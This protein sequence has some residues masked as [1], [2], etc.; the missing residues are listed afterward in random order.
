MPMEHQLEP[1]HILVE[2]ARAVSLAVAERPRPVGTVTFLFSDIEG[3]TRMW[4]RFAAGMNAALAR[5]DALMLRAIEDAGGVVFKTVGDAFCAVFDRAGDA[6]RASLAA[7]TAIAAEDWSAFSSGF[8]PLRVRMALHTGTAS[9][10]DDDYFGPVLNRVA[11]LEAAGHGGQVLVSLVTQQLLRDGLPDGVTLRD[12]GEHTLKDLTH[13][14]HIYEVITDLLV[15]TSE[16][17][18]TAGQLAAGERILVDDAAD[19][20]PLPAALATL[21]AVVRDE[22]RTVTLSPEALR[23]VAR[24]P[25]ADLEVY[26]LGRVAAWS[27]SQFRLD[28]RFVELALLIDQGE[29]TSTGRWAARDERFS[30]LAVLVAAAPDPA[31]VV[32]GPPGSGKSTLLRRLELDASVAALRS[33]A[34]DAPITFYLELNHYK[35]DSPGAPLPLPMEWLASNWRLR[36]PD[37]PELSTLLRTSQV[38]LLLDAL[39]EM[40]VADESA[41]RE[42]TRR[43]KDFIHQTVQQAPRTRLVFTCRSLDYSAPLSTPELRVPQVRIE[44]MSDDQ[45]RQF[46]R[47]YSP[48]DWREIWDELHRSQQLELVRSP[49]FLKLLV[50]QVAD[51]GVVPHGRAALF[52]GFVRQ[53]LRR[54]LER[55]NPLFNPG[56][57]LSTRDCRRLANW[58]WRTEWEL[59]DHGLLIPKLFDLAYS[60]QAEHADGKAAHL[61]L[62]YDAALE[63]LADQRD[64][65]ILR[66][67]M[68]LSVL[69]EDT[70]SDEI[71]YV[72][73]LVQEY[74][75]AQRL[76]TTPDGVADLVRSPWRSDEVQPSLAEIERMITP[77]D[78]L[79]PLPTTGWEQTVLM[80]AAMTTEPDRFVQAVMDGNLAL[81]GWCAAQADVQLSDSTRAQLAEA[82]VVRS[83]DPE[84]DLRARIDAASAVGRMGDPRFER[85]QGTDGEYLLPPMVEIP[86]G[87]YIVG[88]DDPNAED[89]SPAHHVSLAAFRLGMFP[90]TNAEWAC[91]MAAGG[92]DDPRWW[93]TNAARAWQHGE[94]TAEGVRNGLRFWRQRYLQEPGLL[95]ARLSDGRIDAERYALWRTRLAMDDG[96][97][98]EDLRASYRGGRETAPRYWQDE[99]F[100]LPS[101]PVIGVSWFESRAYVLWLSAQSG[102][103]FRLPSEAEWEAAARGSDGR[104]YAFGDFAFEY[105]CN[106]VEAHV[107]RTTPVGVFPSGDTPEGLADM[108]GNI[109]EWTN[110]LFGRRQDRADYRYPYDPDDGRERADA[111]AELNRIARGGGWYYGLDVSS[112]TTR[113]VFYPDGR[114]F[115]VGFRLA[116]WAPPIR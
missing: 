37:L 74:F 13:T 29:E 110:S 15:G 6:L 97:F 98:E 112:A 92:Y 89:E 84:A 108:T 62:D 68:A 7:Q 28:G 10:R 27:Q 101:Q 11:R 99:D 91:F 70:V 8:P 46:L 83:R 48:L 25:P 17:L 30:D 14:E 38:T 4:E 23:D 56:Q 33:G 41:F 50:E 105:A 67:G 9:M 95:D 96:T 59:P 114:N 45:V 80:A 19:A 16:P 85:R 78:P 32:L 43:W 31:L 102:R 1:N 18:R 107:R 88:H 75:A 2:R 69:D 5:H 116:E 26:R 65:D 3:S 22:S 12:L 79:P 100:N 104:R 57:L 44:P 34:A 71:L 115:S 39:N 51:R 58:A 61:R 49:Y 90:V 21:L 66:A 72:H 52:T 40:P 86:S 73:Q 54:E 36:Y 35:A 103:S 76:A 42:A 47:L 60:M 113:Y 64:E 53:A 81:A 111:G 106:T 24:H 109:W 20:Q 82:L 94:G 77:A 93:D 63:I 87:T 55:D